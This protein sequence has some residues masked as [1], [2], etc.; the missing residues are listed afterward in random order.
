MIKLPIYLDYAATTPVD[1]QVIAKMLEFLGDY[2]QFGNPASLTHAYGKAASHAV[3]TAREQVAELIGG[4]ASEII[5]TSGATESVNLAL[6]GAAQLYQ[7]QGKHIVTFKTEHKAVLDTCQQLEKMG[8]TVTYLATLPNGLIDL[9]KFSEALRNDTILVSVMQVNNEIGV[10]QDVDAIAQL[11]ASRGILLHVDAAQS[12]GKLAIDVQR[13][14]I[15]LMS[16]SAHKIY[17]PKGIGALYVRRKP[18]VRVAPLIHGG[19]QELG[20]R[21]GT[22]PTH[23]IAAM[24]EAYRIAQTRMAAD[25][26]HSANL[27]A[28]FLERIASCR[29]FTV[30]GDASHTYPGILN[31]CFKDQLAKSLIKLLPELAIATGSA[32]VN[33]SDEPSYVLRALGL[34]NEVA[35]SALRFSFG[36]FTTP[37]EIDFAAATIIKLLIT[38]NYKIKVEE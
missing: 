30:L 33:N 8:F 11:T 23:Q 29:N 31:I 37:A 38:D 32:C 6:K 16:L 34:S 19:G 12:I 26:Q 4:E 5:W 7:G 21:S 24:G 28:L 13:T 1:A 15:D 36:R 9:A 27:R 3:Q 17:G 18:R 10:I 35:Q 14:P 25:Y 2:G 22:L 20:M